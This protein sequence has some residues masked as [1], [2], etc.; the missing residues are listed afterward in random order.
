[1]NIL[2]EIETIKAVGLNLFNDLDAVSLHKFNRF[3]YKYND[4]QSVQDNLLIFLSYV[5]TST[6]YR[7]PLFQA[8]SYFRL[9]LFLSICALPASWLYHVFSSTLGP[10]D[11]CSTFETG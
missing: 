4:N 11:E 8:C 3:Y 9:T 5:F 10:D 2:E 1:M 6:L 7:S